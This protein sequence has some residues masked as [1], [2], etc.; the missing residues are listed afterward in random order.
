MLVRAPYQPPV[1][2]VEGIDFFP[3][4]RP[5]TRYRVLGLDAKNF[6]PLRQWPQIPYTGGA[7]MEHGLAHMIPYGS[8]MTTFPRER[9]G[10]D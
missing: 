8:G 9:L 3:A 10:R 7:D 4:S 6:S 2:E 1:W 5:R